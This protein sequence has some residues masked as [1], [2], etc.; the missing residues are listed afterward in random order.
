MLLRRCDMVR[1]S[2]K[3]RI[4]Q[5]RSLGLEVY[6]YEGGNDKIAVVYARVSGPQQAINS[7][8]SL[9]RQRGLATQAME[10]KYDAVVVIFMDTSGI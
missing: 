6:V 9:R 7:I 8:Y 2:L 1:R 10:M 3:D 4:Q 5:A